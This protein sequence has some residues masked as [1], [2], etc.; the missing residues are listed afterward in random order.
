M[1]AVWAV[2]ALAMVL[3]VAWADWVMSYCGISSEAM[4]QVVRDGQ[5]RK[6]GG[7]K[8]FYI[9]ETISWI[10]PKFAQ[11]LPEVSARLWSSGNGVKITMTS[12]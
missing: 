7:T 9:L 10:G 3:A 6:T 1:D 11:H 8:M 4:S 2:S 12:G 5:I